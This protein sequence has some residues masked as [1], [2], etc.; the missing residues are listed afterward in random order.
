MKSLASAFAERQVMQRYSEQ[1]RPSRRKMSDRLTLALLISAYTKNRFLQP[2]SFQ[3]MCDETLLPEPNVKH[4]YSD[5]IGKLNLEPKGEVRIS[6]KGSRI[7]GTLSLPGVMAGSGD[8]MLMKS[9]APEA[10][11]ASWQARMEDEKCPTL[12]LSDIV[13]GLPSFKIT[14]LKNGEAHVMLSYADP[15]ISWAQVKRDVLA[16]IQQSQ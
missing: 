2:R 5:V 11:I 6:Y 12:T 9:Y 1:I 4:G 14:S 8:I 16:A 3:Q 13:G 10:V 7:K 15:E